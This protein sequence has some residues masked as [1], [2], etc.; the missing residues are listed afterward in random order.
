VMRGSALNLTNEAV[1]SAYHLAYQKSV[2]GR[3]Q[4]L[5]V[6]ATLGLFAIALFALLDTPQS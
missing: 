4:S 5:A 6:P 1:A 2:V 3:S